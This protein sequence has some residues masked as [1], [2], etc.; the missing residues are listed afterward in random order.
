MTT[1]SHSIKDIAA[2]LGAEALGDIDILITAVAEP[3]TATDTD[4]ALAMGPKY[5]EH[6]TEGSA[7]AAMLWEGADWR[8]LGLEAA[9]IPLRPRFAMS[10]LTA[11]MDKGQGDWSGIHPSAV[12]H[13]TAQIGRQRQ[14]R[15]AQRDFGARADWRGQRDRA[16]VLYRLE[17]DDRGRC[18][19]ARTG[20]HRRARERFGARFIAQPGARIGGDGFSFVTAERSGVEAVRETLGDQ[21]DTQAQPGHAFI[22]WAPCASGM[23]SRSVPTPPSTTA[24]S[25]TR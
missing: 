2:A 16:A 21:G 18:L 9:I 10:G 1:T 15:P 4:L 3:Q 22:P 20:Q 11:M 13:E 5:A 19:S 24:P 12:I 25:A 14:H 17:C 7:R 8:A 6:L 23:M